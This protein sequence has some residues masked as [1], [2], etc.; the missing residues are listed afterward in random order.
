MEGILSGWSVA[1]RVKKRGAVGQGSHGVSSVGGSTVPVRV[2]RMFWW[3]S[4]EWVWGQGSGET[5]AQ[6]AV[7]SLG[8]GPG[9]GRGA[10]ARAATGHREEAGKWELSGE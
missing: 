8:C 2:L 4:W 5:E 9:R 7:R 3:P 10:E 6:R 1:S